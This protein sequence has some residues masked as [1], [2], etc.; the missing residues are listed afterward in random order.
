MYFGNTECIYFVI[1]NEIFCDKNKKIWEK[2][3][4]MI[5]EKLIVNLYITKDI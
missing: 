4:N 1:K 3:S 2:V 5:N